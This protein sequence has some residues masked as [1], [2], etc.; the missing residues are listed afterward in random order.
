MLN[1]VQSTDKSF[2]EREAYQQA[3]FDFGIEE[4]CER[5]SDYSDAD[6]DAGLM[7][8]EPEE[9][10]FLAA[11]L[12]QQLSNSFNGKLLGGFLNAIRHGDSSVLENSVSQEIQLPLV[13]LPTNFPHVQTPHYSEGKNV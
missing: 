11:I 13:G 8:L 3:L 5:I 7:N 6:F 1:T 10:E 2:S 12:I 4:L 9:I